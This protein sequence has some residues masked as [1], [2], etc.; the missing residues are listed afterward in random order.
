MIAKLPLTPK[1]T[2]AS[3]RKRFSLPARPSCGKNRR[4]QH[5]PAAPA[6]GPLPHPGRHPAA[7]RR[8]D[9]AAAGHAGTERRRKPRTAPEQPRRRRLPG[10][11]P[12]GSS[13]SAA[14]P[15]HPSF[16]QTSPPGRPAA[17][18][19]SRPGPGRA[20]PQP[21]E[22]RGAPAPSVLGNSSPAGWPRAFKGSNEAG[23]E[24]GAPL[25]LPTSGTPRG[26]PCPPPA[27]P[28]RHPAAG[29]RTAP[30]ETR[31]RAAARAPHPS[32]LTGLAAGPLRGAG[33]APPPPAGGPGQP[34]NRE[35]WAAPRPGS[36][37]S[38]SDV[39]DTPMRTRA[40]VCGGS[41]GRGRGP[42]SGRASGPPGAPAAA[43]LRPGLSRRSAP[44][45][46]AGPGRGAQAAALPPAGS[47]PERCCRGACVH[48]PVVTN[49]TG[50]DSDRNSSA[51]PRRG[52]QACGGLGNPGF[53]PNALDL[54]LF[55]GLT[56]N[57]PH[58]TRYTDAN[59]GNR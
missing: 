55:C 5:R 28:G 1:S 34:R 30:R 20:D 2:L 39:G 36:T 31:R 58:S 10:R 46:A 42:A 44:R 8:A 45:P 56:P 26:A 15:A 3:L 14:R 57:S 49:G 22:P 21:G 50:R 40:R 47:G 59:K 43:G 24:R 27:G 18:S 41:C 29:P 54:Y 35:R 17:R 38:G 48:V 25:P 13:A 6:P 4:S 9:N 53:L 16:P 32:A 11:C 37:D 19:C 7:A 51:A 12:R 33:P 23:L 52:E